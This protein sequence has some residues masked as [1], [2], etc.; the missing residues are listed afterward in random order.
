MKIAMY[1][2]KSPLKQECEDSFFCNEDKMIYGVCD[3]ATP[4][5][6]FCDEEGHNGAYIASHVFAS[7]FTSLREINGLQGE[8]AKANE[9]L[10]N[11]M[12]EHKVDMRRKDHLWCTCIAAVQIDSEKLE[13]AQ[14][15]DCMIVAILRNGAMQVLTKDTVNGISKRAKKK[16][17]E[18]RKKGL[19]VPEEHVFQD[20]REQLKY[21]R[22]LA[23]MP[24]GYSVA[25]GMQE[26]MNYLQYGE[27]Q[28]EELSGIFICSDGLFH[29]DWSLEQTVAYI[30]KN[31]IEEYVA[32]IERLEGEKRIRPDDKTLITIDF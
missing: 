12:L 18:D 29:P 27:L 4:L 16:R 14:L 15:G 10:Q 31:G 26:A 24:N 19:S 7:H 6:P 9:L 25:N 2:Q 1:Q 5:V 22:Y 13:Y 17:E 20:V 32:I 11:K 23:N 30:R 21:N 28:V 8:V 3:G